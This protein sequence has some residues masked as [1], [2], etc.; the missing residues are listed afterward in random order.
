MGAN[1]PIEGIEAT[2]LAAMKSALDGFVW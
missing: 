1:K 2:L